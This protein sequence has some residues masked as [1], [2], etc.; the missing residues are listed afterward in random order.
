MVRIFKVPMWQVVFLTLFNAGIIGLG[1][2]TGAIAFTPA[3]TLGLIPTLLVL[4]V[5]YLYT[6]R[7][8]RL[9]LVAL[10]KFDQNDDWSEMAGSVLNSLLPIVIWL[11]FFP[12]RVI[13]VMSG[14]VP[15]AEFAW[16]SLSV[17]F[18][19]VANGTG[20]GFSRSTIK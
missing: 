15:L 6:Y 7:I 5:T 12:G 14:W 10:F 17:F 11:V 9:V 16:V 8:I 13:F 20:I 19:G 2:M 18:L 3:V 1:V 4:G